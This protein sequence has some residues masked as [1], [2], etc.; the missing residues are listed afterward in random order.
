MPF[1]EMIRLFKCAEMLQA[2]ARLIDINVA[3]FS[4]LKEDSRRKFASQLR[5]LSTKFLDRKVKD[6]SDVAKN[7][8]MSILGRGNG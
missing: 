6:F 5:S 2:S 4:Q 8:A 3:N 1:S 7:L